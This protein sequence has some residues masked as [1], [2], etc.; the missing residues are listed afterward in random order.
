M[1]SFEHLQW[2]IKC[3]W[4]ES[5]AGVRLRPETSPEGGGEHGKILSKGM[6]QICIFRKLLLVGDNGGREAILEAI[7]AGQWGGLKLGQ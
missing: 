3:K 1:N 4:L 7:A 5:F 2:S 6:T